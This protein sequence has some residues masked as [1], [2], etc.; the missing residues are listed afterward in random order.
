M[1]NKIDEQLIS[2][3]HGDMLKAVMIIETYFGRGND[4]LVNRAFKNF[5]SQE[6]AFIRFNMN[7]LLI[8]LN[9]SI[10]IILSI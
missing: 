9:D 10:S 3:G 1:G 6:L 7:A 5:V 2:A 8:H 4:E